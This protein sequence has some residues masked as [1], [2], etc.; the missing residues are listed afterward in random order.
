[1]SRSSFKLE[2]LEPRV[3]LSGEGIACAFE[4][5]EGD[6]VEPVACSVELQSQLEDETCEELSPY[7]VD[8]PLMDLESLESIDESQS[9]VGSS[10]LDGDEV[11]SSETG[12][13]GGD[14]EAL[15]A[16]DSYQSLLPLTDLV[17]NSTSEGEIQFS[18]SEILVETLN[19]ANAPPSDE[20]S[21]LTSDL[22]VS[23]NSLLSSDVST[24]ISRVSITLD[25]QHTDLTVAFNLSPNGYA[26]E[27][28]DS[29][30]RS[31]HG[32]VELGKEA[33]VV[34]IGNQFI[35]DTLTVNF[36]QVHEEGSL[37][38]QYEGGDGGFDSLVFE[39]PTGSLIT[40][41]AFGPDSGSIDGTGWEIQYTGLEP[42]TDNSD[43]A[44][45]LFTAT[46]SDDEIRLRNAD[47]PG[48]M[49]I[50]SDNG[51]FES[52]EFPNPTSSLTI[53]AGDGDDQIVIESLDPAFVAGE[54]G[55]SDTELHLLG[56]GGMDTVFVS[57]PAD[58][59]LTDA[60]LSGGSE[61]NLLF[62]DIPDQVV[63]SGGAIDASGYSGVAVL[64]PGVPDWTHEGPQLIFSDLTPDAPYP[65]SG[66]VEALAVHPGNDQIIFAATVNGGVWRTLD[67]GKT[68]QALTD[69]FP[70]LSFTS[71]AI[72][73]HDVD[74]LP[75]DASTPVEKL[76]VFAGTGE[77]SANYEG[78]FAVGML[79]SQDGGKTWDLVGVPDMVGLP[80][81]S[82]VAKRI[83]GQDVVLAAAEGKT[84]VE[85]T[86]I[87]AKGT[88]DLTFS[89]QLEFPDTITRSTGNWL[90][91]G[92]DTGYVITVSGSVRNDA[93]YKVA[94]VSPTVLTLESDAVLVDESSV[95]A[96][97]VETE[98]PVKLLKGGGLFRSVDGG[99]TFSK[100]QLIES[101]SSFF[102]FDEYYYP[103]GSVTDLI[104]DPGSEGRLYAAV[105]GGGVY[106]TDD[107][108]A[109]WSPVN[110][111]L[112]LTSDGRDNDGNGFFDDAAETAVGAVRILLAVQSDAASTTNRVY[113]AMLG[114]EDHFIGIFRSSDHGDS[115]SPMGAPP[116]RPDLTVVVPTAIDFELFTFIDNDPSA[117]TINRSRGS[118][119]R[120]GFLVGH[121]LTVTGS[122]SNDGQYVV[123]S[124]THET[125]TLSPAAIL[126]TEAT[127]ADIEATPQ[128][129]F[130][131]ANPDTVSRNV[132]SWIQDG[133]VAGH[134]IEFTK[135]ASNNKI[136]TVSSVTPSDITLVSSEEVSPEI[137]QTVV[138]I[139]AFATAY[140][141]PSGIQPQIHRGSQGGLHFSVTADVDGD[142]Y[143]GGDRPPHIFR[144][145]DSSSQW[146]HITQG[147]STGTISHAD[148]R[149]LLL[150]GA[151]R[152]LDGDDG[153]VYRLLNPEDVATVT[154][155]GS[156]DITFV[157]GDPDQ[158]VRSAGSWIDDG[159]VAGQ[160]IG[161]A[162]SYFIR[163]ND[164]AF[165]IAS[166]TAS[167]LTLIGSDQ[168]AAENLRSGVAIAAYPA[169][170]G[171]PLLTFSDSGPDTIERSAG[172]WIA[173]GF[174]VGHH[175]EVFGS[176]S[177]DGV[178]TIGSLTAGLLTVIE[179]DSLSAEG[180]A[181]DIH[182][183]QNREWKSLN[184]SLGATEI[185]AL[186]YDPVS[187]VI[188]AGTQDNG[189]IAQPFPADG[190]DNDGDGLVDEPDERFWWS[191]VKDADGGPP[192][193]GN[194][195]AVAPIDF[196]GDGQ[197]DAVRRYTMSNNLNYL[198]E[199][200][201]DENGVVIPGSDRFVGLA[202]PT[203]QIH[204]FEVDSVTD[205]LAIDDHGLVTGSG[206]LQVGTLG[207][208]VL[209]VDLAAGELYWAIRISDGVIQ[210]AE[211]EQD[212]L[213][214]NHINLTT[215]GEGTRQLTK[216]FL[217]FGGGSIDVGLDTIKMPNHR[218][219]TGDGPFNLV[220]DHG[221]DFGESLNSSS[222]FWIIRRDNS[223]I[224]LALSRAEALAGGPRLGLGD[225]VTGALKLVRR[226][227]ELL[228]A[229]REIY[230]DGFREIPYVVNEVD[231]SRMLIGLNTLYRSVNIGSTAN[232]HYDG[233][234]T[235]RDVLRLPED[236]DFEALVYGGTKFGIDNAEL[237]YAVDSPFIY[238]SIPNAMTGAPNLVFSDNAIGRDNIT[239]SYGDWVADGFARGQTITVSDSDKNDG[240]YE[241]HSVT[242]TVLTLVNGSRLNDEG[243]VGSVTI[244]HF[245]VEETPGD[246]FI[247]GVAVD[248]DD[249]ENAFVISDANVYQRTAPGKWEVISQNLPSLALRSIEFV[250]VDGQDVLLVGGVNGLFRAIDPGAGVAWT[251]FGG[252]LPNT[253]IRDID[254]VERDPAEAANPHNLSRDDILLVATQGRGAWVTLNPDVY[255]GQET[256]I[257]IV[258]SG[259]NDDV[260]VERRS[261]NASLLDIFVNSTS[262]VYSL[263]ASAVTGILVEGMGG[264]DTLTMDSNHGPLFFPKNIV[265]DGGA[266]S[267]QLILEGSQ[268]YSLKEST[269]S[270]VTTLTLHDV[271]ADQDTTFVYEN[272][273]LQNNL[274]ETSSLEIIR[275]T[276][277]R[278]FRG[279][280]QF[281]E[282][283]SGVE[284]E[285]ALI[286]HSLPRILNG[287]QENDIDPAGDPVEDAT[288][289]V[290]NGTIQPSSG[291]ERLVESGQNGFS[292]SEIGVSILSLADLVAQLD[293]LDDVAGNVILD[294]VSD[295]DGDSV[296]DT[297]LSIQIARR[298]GGSA[299]IVLQSDYGAGDVDLHGDLDASIDVVLD[300]VLGIESINGIFIETAGGASELSI[301]GLQLEGELEGHGRLGF[302]EV[303]LKEAE[304]AVDPDLTFEITL[305]DPSGGDEIRL[306]E[307]T[308]A[309]TDPST[310]GELASFAISGSAVD[311]VVFTTGVGAT[312]VLP[313][314][315]DPFDLGDA[316]ITATWAD[317]SMPETVSLSVSAG[318]GED[319]IGFLDV[320]A[321]RVMEGLETVKNMLEQFSVD[322][323][324]VNQTLDDLLQFVEGFE[325]RI[326]SPLREPIGGSLSVSTIQDMIRSWT[327]GLNE[328]LETVGLHFDADTL[329]LTY[330]FEFDHYF[331]RDGNPL[332]LA[333]DLGGA[334][335]ALDLD[336]EASV[337]GSV[338]L[339]TTLGIDLG[340]LVSGDDF[341]DIFFLTNTVFEG[342][343]TVAFSELNTA[344]SAGSQSLDLEDGSLSLGVTLTVDPLGA[345]VNADDKLSL[346]ELSSASV[347]DLVTLAATGHLDATLPFTAD[348][349]LDLLSGTGL[350][351]E[352]VYTI[353]LQTDDLF[354]A[355]PM[356]VIVSL[357]GSVTLLSQTLE[358]MFTFQSTT[359]AGESVTI[360]SG[361]P[362]TLILFDGAGGGTPLVTATGNGHFVVTED[363]VVGEAEASLELGVAGFANLTGDFQI[364]VN[365]G[366]A[367]YAADFTVFEE[368]VSL[369]LPEGPYL[370]IAGEGVSVDVSMGAYTQTI[371]G[372]FAFEQTGVGDDRQVIL[373]LNNVAA[374]IEAGP[375]SVET[376]E[377][378]GAFLLQSTGVAGVASVGEV[379]LI[380][381]PGVSLNVVDL[382]IRVNNT[383]SDVNDG[384]ADPGPITIE[385]GGETIAFEFS[386]VEEHQHLSVSGSAELVITDFINLNGDFTIERSQL[387]TNADAIDEA[388]LK[389]GVESLNFTLSAGP[390][391]VLSFS[392]GLGAFVFT[393]EGMAGAADLQFELGLVGLAG[394][395]LMEVNTLDRAIEAS[396]P[397][398]SGTVAFNYT[399]TSFVHLCITDAFLQLGS[400]S[401]PVPGGLL[402]DVDTSSGSVDVI[403]K[404]SGT[405]L[406]SIASDGTITTGLSF[407]DFAIAGPFEFVS[408]LRQLLIW[409]S[410]MSD[411]EA[412]NAEIPFTDT[413]L[414]DALDWAQL[415]LDDIYSK[416]ISVELQSG[417]DL[418]G[419]IALEG[420]G[421]VDLVDV[422]FKVQIND[423]TPVEVTVNGSFSSIENPE[424]PFDPSTLVGLFNNAFLAAGAGLADRIVARRHEDAE[425]GI[426]RFV[427]ALQPEAIAEMATLTLVELD[428][429]MESLGFGPADGV[430]GDEDGS[431]ADPYTVE[432]TAVETHR[433]IT[434]EFFVALGDVLGLSIS[435]DPAQLVYT[436]SVDSQAT[437]ETTVPFNFSGDLG[438]LGDVSVEG[439]LR[440]EATVGFAFTLGFDLGASEVPR[441]LTSTFVPTPANGQISDDAEF[442]VFLNDDLSA[443]NFTGANALKAASTLDNQN[444]DDL[445]DDLNDLFGTVL[446]NGDP[447]SDL[448]V[449]QKAGTGLAISVR[450]E[451]LG[452]V[453]RLSIRSQ[454]DDTFATEMGFGIEVLDLDGDEATENDRYFVSTSQSGIKGLFLDDVALSADV[455]AFTET[456]T[457]TYPEANPDGLTGGFRLG[458]VELSTNEGA[459]GTLEYD[460]A[461]PTEIG[462]NLG[463]QNGDSGETRFYLPNLFESLTSTSFDNLIT[464]PELTGSFLARLRGLSV[465]G[466]D[467]GDLAGSDPEI[468][469][470]IP[471]INDV[472]YN[473]DPYDGGNTGLFL[474]YPD[475]GHL[476]NF[477]DFNFAQFINALRA[478]A[479]NLSEL[480]G[481]GFLDQKI[482]VIDASVNDLLD[483]ASKFAE[484]VEEAANQ[485]A[486]SLQAAI[487]EL[488]NQIEALFNLDPSILSISIDTNGILPDQLTL[489]GGDAS[490]PATTTLNPDGD[491]NGIVIQSS[492]DG[493]ENNGINI[494]LL[495]D[496]SVS[497]DDAKV[498]W[499]EVQRVL[500]L[501]IRGGETTAQ[502]LVDAI[503]GLA[504][505]PFAASL[506]GGDS[507]E[508]TLRTTALKFGL[509]F[510]AAYGDLLPLQLDL[511]ALVNQLAGDSGAADFL[512][513]VTTLIQVE[514]SGVLE[515]SASASL[516][517]DFGIDVTNPTNPEVFFY[518]T[519]GISLLAKVLGRDIE[520]E[521]SLGSVIGIFIED[522]EVT[523]DQDGDPE[524]DAGD[525]DQGVSFSVT[526]NDTNGDA[527]I[528]LSENWLTTD[529]IDIALQGGVSVSLP[530]FAPVEGLP[531][532]GTGDENED[533]HPDNELFIEIA[534]FAGL[535]AGDDVV[536]IIAPDLNNLVHNVDFCAVLENA[537]LLIDGL[538]R[539]LGS[540]EEGL[541][542]L[543]AS[544]DLPMLGDGF[545]GAANFISDFRNGLLASIQNELDNAGGSA[546][547]LVENA[548]KEAFWGTLGPDGLDLLVDPVTG[549]SFDPSLGHHQLSV[550]LDCNAGLVVDLRLRKT[551][552]L[553]DTSENPI[554][555]DIGVPGFGLEVDGNVSVAVGFDLKFGFGLNSEDGFYFDSSAGADDPELR[556]FF[557][558]S[559]P[560][561]TATGSLAFLQLQVSDDPDD[562]S[563]FVGQFVVDLK[564]PNQDGKLT[565]SEMSSSGVQF[566]DIFDPGLEA[567]AD[568]NLDLDASFGGDAA[569]PRVVAEF[570]L[571]WVW[572]LEN[573]AQSPE[574]VLSDIALDLGSFISDFL[575]PV[576]QEV[577]KVTEPLDPIIEIATARLPVLSDL[578]G[579]TITLLDLAEIYGVL[580]PST[581][582]FIETAIK[583]VDIIN[584][585]PTGSGSILIPFGSFALGSDENGER[586]QI[587]VLDALAEADFAGIVANA[588][589][590]DASETY[591]NQ[592]SGFAG[593]LDSLDNFII[594]IF[595][596]PA[597]LFNLFIGEPVSL[598]E[599]RMPTFDFKFTYTQKIPIYPPLY[600]HFGGSIGATINIGFGYDTFGIQK[601]IS[602]E[603]KNALDLLDGFHVLDFDENGNE[604]PELELRGEIFAGA[605]INLLI[606]EAGVTGG[607]FAVIEFDLNDVND[608]GK[609]RISEIVANAQIDPRC[610]F[611]I[612]GEMGL[613]LEAFLSVDLFFFS[614]DK[615][616]R[617]AEITLFE[618]DIICPEPVLASQDGAGVLTLHMGSRA[619]DREEIDTNDSAETFIVSHLDGDKDSEVVEVQW[620]NYKQTYEGITQIYVPDAGSGDDWIDLRGVLVDA[621]ISGGVGNDTIYLSDGAGAIARGDEGDDLIVASA[622]MT[623]TG[624]ELY[625]GDGNDVFSP[626]TVA[627]TIYGEG[628]ADV[629]S[630]TSEGDFLY[631]GDGEDS[632]S[633][634]AGDDF[635]DGGNGSDELD[636]H[637]GSDQILGGGGAD[638]LNGG[639]DDDLLEGGAGDDLLYGSS[640]NDLLIGGE[641]ADK[642]YGHG[643]ID[644]LIGDE[645]EAI[646]GVAPSLA[647]LALLADIPDS[648]L[649]VTGLTGSGND[650]LIGG[651]NVDVIFGGDGNDFLYGG[652]MLANGETEIIEEDHNDFFDG[653]TGN[654]VI[655]GDDA[656]GRTGDRDTGI[657]IRGSV[658][659]DNNK[660]DQLDDEEVGFGAI[661]IDLHKQ[662]DDSLIASEVSGSDGAFVFKGLDPNNYYLVASK[663]I[664]LDY[665]VSDP[666]HDGEASVSDSDIIDGTTGRTATFALDFDE[667]ET[668]I[669]IGYEGDPL[670]S[671]DDISVDEMGGGTANAVFTITLSGPQLFIAS[672]DYDTVD[673]TATVAEGD[674]EFTSGTLEFA[675]G[676]TSAQVTVPIFG[677]L[678]YE[679]HEQFSLVLSDPS[680]GVVLPAI[681]SANA[682]IV[683]DDPIPQI[684][685]SDFNPTPIDYEDADETRPIYDEDQ[686]AEFVISLTNPSYHQIEVS[687]TTDVSITSKGLAVDDAAT[688]SG[689]PDSDFVSAAGTI[690]F[691][692]GETHQTVSVVVLDDDDND[693]DGDPG[694]VVLDEPDET[695]FVTLS[696]AKYALISDDRGVGIIEDDD[697]SVSVSIAPVTPYDPDGAGPMAPLPFETHLSE[698]NTGSQAVEF[699]VTLSERSALPVT[700]TYSTSPGTAVGTVFSKQTQPIE[701]LPDYEPT[702]QEGL[703]DH[704]IELVFEPGEVSKT[705]TVEVFGDN[706]VEPAEDF[707]V[708][709]LNAENADIAA[710]PTTENNH[711][712]VVIENDDTISS[713]DYGPYSIWFSDETY[714]VDEPEV[715][716]Q[717]AEI[718][719][720]RAD[721]S[722]YAFAVLT[723]LDLTATAGADYDPV[724]RTL[725]VFEPEE[726]FKTVSIPVHADD[727]AEGDEHI[728]LLLQDP[729]GSLV[730]GT[731]FVASLVI[732]D[733]DTPELVIEPPIFASLP[734]GIDIPGI[735]ENGTPPHEFTVSLR[736]GVLAPPGGVTAFYETVAI[737]AR[738]GSDFVADSGIVVIPEGVNSV[739]IE[740]VVVDDAIPES[741]E[742]FAVRLSLVE[743]ADMSIEDSVAVATIFDD[744]GTEVSGRVFYDA[745]E[746]G[747]QDHN[748]RGINDVDVAISWFE[749]GAEQSSIVQ[750]S[751]VGGVDGV[752][753]ESVFLG[754]VSIVVDAMS[755]TSPYSGFGITDGSGSYQTTTHNE[756][757]AVEF[758]G[759]EGISPFEPVGYDTS[760]RFDTPSVT[761]DVGR[762]G[763]D[764][765]IFGGPGDDTID[766]GAGDDHIVGGHW[767]TATDV[768]APVNLG[769]YDVDLN[770]VTDPSGDPD[771]L[772]SVYDEGPIFEVD[773]SGLPPGGTISGQIWEDLNDSDTQDGGDPLFTQ[774]VLVHLYDELGNA[775]NSVV[776]QD[777]EYSFDHLYLLEG[778]DPSGYLV[779][780]DLPQGW[781]FVSPDIGGD[782]TIDSDV[783]SGNRSSVATVSLAAPDATDLDAG[784]KLSD[785]LPVSN[786]GG[787]EF[788][789]V[790]YTVSQSD[791][792]VTIEVVRGDSTQQGAVVYRTEDG[793]AEAGTNYDSVTGILVFNVG[794]TYRSFEIP[795]HD[796]GL[797]ISETLEFTVLLREATGRPLD[798]T[799]VY[800]YGDGQGTLT[801]DDDIQG[802]DDWDLILGDS[803]SIPAAVVIADPASLLTI[804][805]FGGPGKDSIEGGNGPD[806]IDSQLDDDIVAGGEGQDQVKAGLGD[807]EVWAEIDDDDLDG[808]HGEDTLVS[809][810]DVVRLELSPDML[811]HHDN[812]EGV[813]PALSTFIL[814]DSF[815][816]ARLT[817]GATDNVFVIS[818]W[819]GSVYVAASGGNDRLSV[820]LDSDM[821]LTDV[822]LP[823]PWNAIFMGVHGF[824]KDGAVSLPDGQTYHLGSVEN[825]QLTGGPSANHLDA[826][827]Y[828][829]QA[830]LEGAGGDDVL[831]GGSG[832]DVFLF[833][834]DDPIGADTI[835]G[836][837]GTD[838]LDFSATTLPVTVDLSNMFVLQSANA[839][840]DLTIN[841]AL[842][843]VIGG[844]GDDI[845]TG[846]DLDNIL[847]GGPGDDTL[848]G[849][850]GDETYAF[851][852]DE[853]WGHET[854]VEKIGEGHDIIDFSASSTLSVIF[855]LSDTAAQAV[856][857]NLTLTVEDGIGGSGEIEGIIG[858]AQ[859]DTLSGNE[860]DNTLTG[861]D[862]VD[863]LNGGGGDDLLEGGTGD[864][865]LNGGEGE[866][867]IRESE[868]TDFSLSDS[869]L[870]RGSGEV[871]QL[872]GIEVAH[873]EG[874]P[875]TSNTFDLTGWTGTGSVHGMDDTDSSSLPPAY[876][877]LLIMTADVD[878]V[879]TDTDLTM[880]DDSGS[881][882]LDL[883][884]IETVV[885]SGGPSA[886]T[887]D[888]SAFTGQVTLIG[889]GGDDILIGGSGA[890]ILQGGDGDDTLI[891]GRGSDQLEGGEGQDMV[892]DDLSAY[893]AGFDF[894]VSD[895][896]ITLE[897]TTPVTLPDVPLSESDVLKSIE[898]VQLVGG[899]QPDRFNVT[900]WM[901]GTLAIDGGGGDDAIIVSGNDRIIDEESDEIL[902]TGDDIITLSDTNLSITGRVDI[903]LTSI[904]RA[905]LAGLGGDDLI[906]ASAFNG[907][908]ILIGGSD[909]DQFVPGV[910]TSVL[911]GDDPTD[912][913]VR[914]GDDRFIFREDGIENLVLIQGG[915]G[916]DTLDFSSFSSAVSV[917]LS[918][919]G[920]EQLVSVGEI[921]LL[922]QDD[923]FESVVGGSN[924]DT[925]IGNAAD[926]EF[927][928]GGGID[929]IDGLD[930]VDWVIEEADEDF[931]LTDGSL[932]MGVEVDVLLGI[933]RARLTGGESANM[934]DGSAFTGRTELK[935][936]GDGDVLIGG[937][938]IDVL[939]GGD[940]DDLLQGAEGGDFY[941]FD[942][943]H[944]LG[945]DVIEDSGLI[946][947]DWLDFRETQEESI[948]VSLMEGSHIVHG[949]N[950]TISIQVGT[951]I[952]GIFGGNQ[953]D[954]LLG[955]GID[956]LMFGGEGDDLID[957]GGGVANRVV[958]IRDADMVLSNTS[959]MIGEEV[960]LLT[961]I[962]S[963]ILFGEASSNE[964]DAS[965]F[966]LGSV[967][968]SGGGGSDVLIGGSEDD[969][970]N[971]GEGDDVLIGGSGDDTLRGGAGDDVLDGGGYDPSELGSDDDELRGGSGNDVYFFDASLQLGTDTVVEFAGEGFADVLIGA[972]LSG[973]DVDLFEVGLQIVSD[974]LGL[975]LMPSQEVEDSF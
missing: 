633:G 876:T 936:L 437:Y 677:D 638:I 347:S 207:R 334:G 395:I 516:I 573:G 532:G 264:D 877:D 53:D 146:D 428:E 957:G 296:A 107:G 900:G 489:S 690:V 130:S 902:E 298:L 551:V 311:D 749:D 478:L 511:N 303:Y 368:P 491:D 64:V 199:R 292:L 178:Y 697:D 5:I 717:D 951:V 661:T 111:G 650:F 103:T 446:Y 961:G 15:D 956:N 302:L 888:A 684:A 125:L 252:G 636:G 72:H 776:T 77:R 810:R 567:V 715:G 933:E 429:D 705:F 552:A 891:G 923:D 805:T 523:I 887:L 672:V 297:T 88:P 304:L 613:F 604:R 842:E 343:V 91:D 397:V 295:R 541:D 696:N 770:V 719:I 634:G 450:D 843:G 597:E 153:G 481:F 480:S 424:D 259:G 657:E 341:E 286:G 748:E 114:T 427:I 49:I 289:V 396:V 399:D 324:E 869:V 479:D 786:S 504:G 901:L 599:W 305:Q 408:L 281:F 801:D 644:L 187:N 955:N 507:G 253:L 760:S 605:S 407:D 55:S 11:D 338:G 306:S 221:S 326:L 202:Q 442:E 197:V 401:V 653:G 262:P 451:H 675:P 150:D 380:G 913:A 194:T 45:R 210:L 529:I 128:L 265:F 377:G 133:I 950:L 426:D 872:E 512:D 315:D 33:T 621:D 13:G 832:D 846:N 812:E 714:V 227:S 739:P 27:F 168:L 457:G 439:L 557:E 815:E 925:L 794:E 42:I 725:V 308:T 28:L 193:D 914:A 250:D 617:F 959:L 944:S 762:G 124:V 505:T 743:G 706:R 476:Q 740:V 773:L 99:E 681:P 745:N 242:P 488:E 538:D 321:E 404:D 833:D 946:G 200:L 718:G 596:N 389:V 787:F 593:D 528:Y 60:S 566:G 892:G 814:N 257:H 701:D 469:V 70:S 423:E 624:V 71:L 553:V 654:D 203:K 908:T 157:D 539:L 154:M 251:E 412:F 216:P 692:S 46:G 461:T 181:N 309:L 68:W 290:Q 858:G 40:Y 425:P 43:I 279:I 724:F 141:G 173:D 649:Q 884:D 969:E 76:N 386:G 935:G 471:D 222:S 102:W 861:G 751:T 376:S 10:P 145:D 785:V 218:L 610:I 755:V 349:S 284:G 497:G 3:L 81:S 756:S 558:A 741:D 952:E 651:G 658:W 97:S 283:E 92:F 788:G 149:F 162:G 694:T 774:E 894:A 853:P 518:D 746:N 463:L 121:F 319:L 632:I 839:N 208:G 964:I 7:L 898:S 549:E 601:F 792:E 447:V 232:P 572:D 688:P 4:P 278:V 300:L 699:S 367:S 963:A 452:I 241:V 406:V 612:H 177:N 122:G 723:A 678:M 52:I 722:S 269:Q 646:G 721:D 205:Q 85:W 67:G 109:N 261:S 287:S 370:R 793:S 48:W 175:I 881:R 135:T 873:L 929:F 754:Q 761:E 574:I 492:G 791:V 799:L 535:L 907:T 238:V 731:P 533:G 967:V 548:L 838:W 357:D 299:D 26:V 249:Y 828:S 543:V 433:Y 777:G 348:L 474:T 864:D 765:T 9:D 563:S 971:G 225:D 837:S 230:L 12:A 668:S 797:G 411:T 381:V 582:R 54:S 41:T 639:Q 686:D 112:S 570:H 276:L 508:G 82:I 830:I 683:N 454:M 83:S 215:E 393:E 546:V 266:D 575:E 39:A 530:I 823:Y 416:L 655:F 332:D 581:V 307:L 622:A 350:S 666:A 325:E 822:N 342:D 893:A 245:G 280:S 353:S 477:Q 962:Q 789:E 643:G 270:G 472:E 220:T 550:M 608:D 965:D 364:R 790:A 674:Y 59:T 545:S 340:G 735:K 301:S 126:T 115:W 409:F 118:W 934:I 387:D 36:P 440:L 17:V 879:L 502:T 831:E 127:T 733:G 234:N 707:F 176:T 394:D 434:E 119:I 974:H 835:I 189:D 949:T 165:T 352:G 19:A 171:N 564:D 645:A 180:P 239:R 129:T 155:S 555:F 709:L 96:V 561:L 695:F 365:T 499:D 258:G 277:A 418:E 167:T 849:G 667:V 385:V 484:L 878:F 410:D 313:W 547:T 874:G 958:A 435:Y 895:S 361:D 183:W 687:W 362:F 640:G 906:D 862:G 214:G 827:G 66:A 757:Q 513:A 475:L 603:D 445:A 201:F 288:Q 391:D 21:L 390:L 766:G 676:Q 940:G 527:R 496:S 660:N 736:D 379:D 268:S 217:S 691:E 578:A 184:A 817:A 826:S 50:E 947:V 106:R 455:A 317:V 441:V 562:P 580:E 120:D 616:W 398:A 937:S 860:N 69:E 275:D 384:E 590:S 117:D 320:T 419:L 798:E 585:L 123:D 500:T 273:I 22:T 359:I 641:G 753:A 954:T 460:G 780:F 850:L 456:D 61:F 942:V 886:N 809:V 375:L 267:N 449:A 158:I 363:G 796:T 204:L 254:F 863:I 524:T 939:E 816:V 600:A 248:P 647:T 818:D 382:G 685:I 808:Q 519:T 537:G 339:Q 148:S 213:E 104:A 905:V 89:D 495:G 841:D 354:G 579:E 108:G 811:I 526:L 554:D 195:T 94:S 147:K 875:E 662:S 459:F 890:D 620:G 323:P 285:L 568:L 224:Q 131:D 169:L 975:I 485:P 346:N 152:L 179:A 631:G 438:D 716:S 960:D 470:W 417:A 467:I 531:L 84:V 209:P 373:G 414:G 915:E 105:R 702:P 534:D 139:E 866:D 100:T 618:F 941:V 151:G 689:L 763:T 392:D 520:I 729:T 970:L 845:L 6:V 611:D 345:D 635:I 95:S 844:D 374:T 413:T 263:P 156:P 711:V 140:Q 113:A 726:T 185:L 336:A 431:E 536:T 542:D 848:A 922:I 56:G 972:G 973:V 198:S 231:P 192:G 402:I 405:V 615:T 759:A 237:Y 172:S 544:S 271:R 8:V 498:E 602:S 403:E 58:M 926:N 847:Q 294:E 369:D 316:E 443:V 710:D 577:R 20:S 851:D 565:F 909:S 916:Q 29:N 737:S 522:G 330:D 912:A 371:S 244:G 623:A 778:G 738:E 159:F 904:E 415:F 182:V 318:A 896:L 619:E 664:G 186:S 246:E 291:L 400:T 698:G 855:D 525:D 473:E 490:N 235:I 372:D 506:V 18:F 728:L 910:G 775:V 673:L 588:A 337:S 708:N 421:I 78:G 448:L 609:V 134:E 174:G 569:F 327:R 806:Y 720:R 540:I 170:E 656:M 630:G 509:D 560:G 732:L 453:N 47:Q 272:T 559:I 594:P 517:L 25:S 852:T 422:K 503:N 75:V 669:G 483:Y 436:Y 138:G 247:I 378:M 782:D 93:D 931:V 1:M 865:V 14:S 494:R 595:K 571:D 37:K 804:V 730:N 917:D 627:I 31:V 927:T 137:I 260:R 57:H 903:Q 920:A 693:I 464:G 758:L 883:A 358:G 629:I 501:G 576:L 682:T 642:A 829:R 331:G 212:A 648:G 626:G 779:A 132:G 747:F 2:A 764:D 430:Y 282:R 870:I 767:M 897:E 30:D 462:V 101:E 80:I 333:F 871:D 771:S 312:A 293:D 482:P 889:A 356:E 918:N 383:E 16:E 110:S 465:N 802:G 795:I 679:E 713:V 188:L 752:Y 144:W 769:D 742:R 351:T 163:G 966:T 836:Q 87:K 191:E 772:H 703:I 211:T 486:S 74:G 243:P 143:L 514:G 44:D 834:A 515:V 521:T 510:T 236:Q 32:S 614:I 857:A 116:A 160:R 487:D 314:L 665:L 968:L 493:A 800:I 86:T 587:Q 928:G 784:V 196:D 899:L 948:S 589:S 335:A 366:E 556:V 783:L 953:A 223:T 360:L 233:L 98:L 919:V 768:H 637:A 328:E 420:D 355:D 206:P 65:Q 824:A 219:A 598:I 63:V 943:D 924:G 868:D 256:V 23:G 584:T 727:L 938:G 240:R 750:T 821:T 932:Q 704:Q 166:V 652:N 583:V 930:G 136:Y 344:M 73:S 329:E 607:I 854:V 859:D 663:P 781:G 310:L 825:V 466:F 671:I 226:F 24:E 867:T 468:S 142:V 51:S 820:S 388:V 625:G 670:L 734:W 38:I 79:R 680:N 911:L 628:G 592:V 190:L 856:N 882:V 164:G 744:D 819:E 255:L 606:A 840:L 659:F 35:D 700:V 62:D 712:T 444:I 161:V 945:S 885:L 586:N 921:R 90:S 432:Q 880:T 34:V 322:I 803:G 813:G 228:P 458:F 807:D 274:E 591:M 229:D